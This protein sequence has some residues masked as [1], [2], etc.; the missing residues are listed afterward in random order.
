MKLDASTLRDLVDEKL[1]QVPR[2]RKIL[3]QESL[4]LVVEDLYLTE[5]ARYASFEDSITGPAKFLYNSRNMRSTYRVLD[6]ALNG[7]WQF[8]GRID[9]SGMFQPTNF[10][11]ATDPFGIVFGFGHG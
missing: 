1:P 5:T 6:P 3:Q 2:V 11:P 4:F 10:P 8:F 9:Y 7:Y